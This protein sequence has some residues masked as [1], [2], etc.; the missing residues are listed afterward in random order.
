MRIEAVA[1]AIV[2][3]FIFFVAIAQTDLLIALSATIAFLI[4]Y[5]VI[6]FIIV[7]I[8]NPQE[9]Y[10]VKNEHLHITRTTR[11]SQK[12]EKIPLKSIKK[13]KFDK[14]FLGGYILSEEKRHSLF[15]NAL[16]ELKKFEKEVK[17]YAK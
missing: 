17:K 8:R 12:K 5:T 1:V 6:S 16:S 15:F 10:H 11:F 14:L 7:N 9:E 3:V 4:L 13:H 2:A